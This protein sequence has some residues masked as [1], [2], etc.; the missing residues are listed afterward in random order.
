M[1]LPQL[2]KY[3]SEFNL[4]EPS[5]QRFSGVGV[6]LIDLVIALVYRVVGEDNHHLLLLLPIGT[7]LVVELGVPIT[8]GIK[9]LHCELPLYSSK[10]MMSTAPSE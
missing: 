8:K 6:F 1:P 7:T 5:M 10:T 2:T 3:F 9:L 4:I